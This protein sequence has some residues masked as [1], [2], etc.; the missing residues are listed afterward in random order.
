MS[1]QDTSPWPDEYI[2][3]DFTEALDTAIFTT[4]AVG[5][6]KTDPITADMVAEVTDWYA[7][8]NEGG[9]YVAGSGDTGTELDLIAVVR[10][11]DGRWAS[12]NAW[13]DYTG[14]GC[15]DGSE[16]AI[17]DTKEQVVQFGLD[18]DGRRKLNLAGAE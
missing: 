15:Q 8:Y 14:W 18:E 5:A 4:A 13:N 9:P 16:I 6:P 10:L 7:T 12:I 11:K 1:K 3:S 2:A 17:G